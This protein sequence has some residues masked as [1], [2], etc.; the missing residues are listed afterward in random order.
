MV[1]LYARPAITAC[2][3]AVWCHADTVG[4]SN[5]LA[6]KPFCFGWKHPD[7]SGKTETRQES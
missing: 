5:F 1:F 7:E 4:F 2:L 3:A 6:E